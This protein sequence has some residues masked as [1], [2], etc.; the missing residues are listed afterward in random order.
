MMNDSLTIIFFQMGV[1]DFS[2][3]L[4]NKR[5]QDSPDEQDRYVNIPMIWTGIQTTNGR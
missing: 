1:I 4:N 3:Y 5:L 2:L